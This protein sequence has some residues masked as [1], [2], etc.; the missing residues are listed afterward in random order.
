LGPQPRALARDTSGQRVPRSHFGPHNGLY[1]SL[2][3]QGARQGDVPELIAL[4][5]R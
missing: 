5:L 3:V 4:A 2:T 1:I